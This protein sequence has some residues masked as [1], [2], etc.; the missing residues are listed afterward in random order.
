MAGQNGYWGFLVTNVILDVGSNREEKI[1][2]TPG[3][4]TLGSAK[5]SKLNQAWQD[6]NKK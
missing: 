3:R 5:R 4:G 6:G 1:W 2:E